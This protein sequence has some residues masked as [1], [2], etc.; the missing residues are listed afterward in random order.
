MSVTS[1]K[2]NTCDYVFF[3]NNLEKTL[4]HTPMDTLY[5]SSCS[6]K[7]R[8]PFT[9]NTPAGLTEAEERNQGPQNPRI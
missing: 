8:N 7:S 2:N 4:Q 3:R 9:K 5:T 6:P 1:V